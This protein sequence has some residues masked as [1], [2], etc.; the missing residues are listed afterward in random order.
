MLQ[1]FAQPIAGRN[2]SPARRFFIDFVCPKLRARQHAHALNEVDS[3]CVLLLNQ[4]PVI[5]GLLQFVLI[6]LNPLTSQQCQPV[7]RLQ[8]LITFFRCEGCSVQREVD[9]K[10]HQTVHADVARFFLP[11][12]HPHFRSR[13]LP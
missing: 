3:V 11:D 1:C 4:M 10:V 13:R 8:D 6:N 5:E 7:R 2:S 9:R 12:R